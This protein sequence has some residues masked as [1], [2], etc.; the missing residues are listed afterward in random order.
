MNPYSANQMAFQQG[1]VAHNPHGYA[2]A[3]QAQPNFGASL[4]ALAAMSKLGK[5]FA[6]DSYSS[7]S[8][9]ISIV[10]YDDHFKE[11]G[12]C[13][14]KLEKPDGTRFT[15]EEIKKNPP[16]ALKFGDKDCQVVLPI[17]SHEAMCA[18][19]KEMI[20]AYMNNAHIPPTKENRKEAADAISKTLVHKFVSECGYGADKLEKACFDKG[21][22]ESQEQQ[23]K[24]L[25]AI[26]GAPADAAEMTAY[27]NADVGDNVTVGASTEPKVP[28]YTA[29]FR[30]WP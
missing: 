20:D 2:Y 12:W 13:Q 10:K 22:V 14:K 11:K 1:G 19:T 24:R 29:R 3:A 5:G 6:S 4:T 25:V 21:I 27:Y 16:L 23:L 7:S 9:K 26:T 28:D 15:E 17:P 8:S 18:A 30:T